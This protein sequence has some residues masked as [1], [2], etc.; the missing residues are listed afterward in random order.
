MHPMLAV[1]IWRQSC[2][3]VSVQAPE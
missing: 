2:T 1:L 3:K